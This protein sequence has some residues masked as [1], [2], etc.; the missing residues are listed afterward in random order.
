MQHSPADGSPSYN[1]AYAHPQGM[2]QAQADVAQPWQPPLP[3]DYSQYSHAQ[4]FPPPNHQQPDPSQY[5]S[6]Y[7]HQ[8]QAGQYAAPHNY[9]YTAYAQQPGYPT[10]PGYPPQPYH[11]YQQPQQQPHA[12]HQYPHA[13]QQGYQ[14]P[15]YDYSHTHAY[16]PHQS[17]Q[18]QQQQQQ[19]HYSPYH[20]HYPTQPSPPLPPSASPQ[21]QANQAT[22]PSLAS[23]ATAPPIPAA[24][25]PVEGT[26]PPL[27]ATPDP[28]APAPPPPAVPIEHVLYPPQ[29]MQRPA[30]IALIIRGIPGS[31]KSWLAR[32]V[33]E[34]EA[35]QG[36]RPPRILSIDPYF[37]VDMDDDDDSAAGKGQPQERYVHDPAKEA[38][39]ENALFSKLAQT[40][41]DRH[42]SFVIV[43][44]PLRRAAAVLSCSAV[45]R[46]A[47]YD[48]FVTEPPDQD[49]DRCYQRNAHQRTREEV[50]EAARQHE[51]PPPSLRVIDCSSVTGSAQQAQLA[52]QPPL[53][54]D[55]GAGAAGTDSKR[56]F[57]GGAGAEA[58]SDAKRLRDGGG[59]GAAAAPDGDSGSDMD[60]GAEGGRRGGKG[61]APRSRWAD[62]DDEASEDEGGEGGADVPRWMR[63][64]KQ[65]RSGRSERK[66]SGDSANIDDKLREFL[67]QKGK[68]KAKKTVRWPDQ[69]AE[70]DG[71]FRI[72][73]VQQLETVH[74]LQGLG[75]PAAGS[76]GP[77]DAA[78]RPHSALS[79]A[80]AVRAEHRVERQLHDRGWEVQ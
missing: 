9:A 13:A 30:S 20:A 29:R 76:A 68:G 57:L 79:F 27:P 42:T 69:V 77:P 47:Q 46:A 41:A 50:A 18:Q 28:P 17:Y 11:A 15:S 74:V 8:Y 24:S 2:Q 44:A 45:A 32:R 80:D 25:A 5:A 31:G 71:S 16:N 4:T 78:Q 49:P 36:G 14:Y 54:D 7:Q 22:P 19:Q 10:Q 75:P 58:G 21:P 67:A 73:R 39:Y 51:P 35:E 33:R 3:P 62:D 55:S 48:V 23:P 43:D 72:G 63:G 60:T 38:T 1:P 26:P 37:M 61:S 6:S 40:L 65:V 34:I 56:K 53:P 66:P 59:P 52:A 70:E 64:D 12:A